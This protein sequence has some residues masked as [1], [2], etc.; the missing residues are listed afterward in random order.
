MGWMQ[1][2][3]RNA[4]ISTLLLFEMAESARSP[5]CQ[6]TLYFVYKIYTGYLSRMRDWTV[7]AA[8]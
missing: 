7:A 8:Q 6:A 2:A 1:S 3:V 5:F 4:T